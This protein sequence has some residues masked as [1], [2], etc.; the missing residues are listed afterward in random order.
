MTEVTPYLIVDGA[1]AA[2]EFYLKAF[3]AVEDSRWTDAGGRTG[4][5]QF[6]IGGAVFYLADEH[7]E[8]GIRGPRSLGGSSVSLMLEVPDADAAL[9]RAAAA[10]AAVDHPT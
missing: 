3:G 5:A 1:A 10:G 2:L 6:T 9:D 4:H 8:S 7:P